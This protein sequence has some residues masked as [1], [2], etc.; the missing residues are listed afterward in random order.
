MCE[1]GDCIHLRELS[2]GPRGLDT[3]ACQ[4]K[5]K[6]I[7]LIISLVVVCF[8][9]G[10]ICVSEFWPISLLALGSGSANSSLAKV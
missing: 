6:I 10:I 1:T 2:D 3:A 9:F 8:T 4:K 5:K 7:F